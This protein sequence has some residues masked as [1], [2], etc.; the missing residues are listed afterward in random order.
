MLALLAIAAT[1]AGQNNTNEIKVRTWCPNISSR[2][3]IST[4]PGPL[5][6]DCVCSFAES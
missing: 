6:P 5:L 4:M 1:G 2:P 3:Q